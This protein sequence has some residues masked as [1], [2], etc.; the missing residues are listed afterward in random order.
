MSSE[1]AHDADALGRQPQP[2]SPPVKW[3]GLISYRGILAIG[4]GSL[5]LWLFFNPAALDEEELPTLLAGILLLVGICLIVVGIVLIVFV[6]KRFRLLRDVAPADA[7]VVI[8]VDD[9]CDST[10]Y[11]LDIRL[12]DGEWAIGAVG[13]KTVDLYGKDIP[14]RAQVWRDPKTGA[15]YAVAINGHH[16]NTLPHA[17]AGKRSRQAA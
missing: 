5:F 1:T 11:T 8:R 2:E 4:I 17:R 9:T 7:E 14:H 6:Y 13:N 15:P 12:P 16:F 10:T 3:W